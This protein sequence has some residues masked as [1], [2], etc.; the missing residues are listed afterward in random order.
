M[1]AAGPAF[2]LQGV[3]EPRGARALRRLGQALGGMAAL[4]AV[5]AAG[6]TQYVAWR[7][8]W[9]PALGDPLAGGVYAPWAV[10]DWAKRDWPAAAPAF[11]EARSGAVLAFTLAGALVLLA[12]QRGKRRPKPHEGVHGTARWASEQECRDAGLLAP[13][14][15]APHEGLFVGAFET[16]PGRTEYLRATGPVNVLGVGPLRSGKTQGI[17][18]PNLLSWMGSVIVNDP[19]GELWTAT[20]GWRKKHAGTA[21]LRWAPGDTENTARYNFLDE[22]R[23]GQAQEFGDVS[24]IIESVADP[25]GAGFDGKDHWLPTAAELLIGVTLYNLHRHR[26][27]AKRPA[28]LADTRR[29]L[30]DPDVPA[31]KLFEAML[32]NRLA[33]GGK[34]HEGIAEIGRAQLNR[35]EKERGSVTSTA[36]RMMRL[37]ADPVVARNTSRS[38]FRINDLMDARTP[39][40]LYKV[41]PEDRRL[42]LLPLARLL[43]TLAMNK[44][45]SAPMPPG[46]GRPHRHPL[47]FVGEEF[48]FYGRMDDLVDRLARCGQAGIQALLLVQEYPQLLST[49][50]Q[51][52]AVTG[53]CHV[54]VFHTPNDTRT[55]ELMSALADRA[56]V[57][58]EQIGESGDRYGTDRG[59]NRSFQTVSRSLLTPGEAARLKVPERDA[60]GRVTAP[61]QVMVSYAGHFPVL[62]VQ[63]LY[64][65]D[66]TFR[67]RAAVPPPTTDRLLP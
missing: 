48:L 7:L 63:S 43:L 12:S 33:P 13:R 21:V 19:K 25:S 58:T 50:G 18:V 3:P 42:Q 11:V 44:L 35:P 34:R 14:R 56:T 23:L 52:E 16:K 31:D 47:L 65:L 28:C 6:A 24:T 15:G 5:A 57:I 39:V 49:Y 51:N 54:K 1:T 22:V 55:A 4:G 40:S 66:E 29:A 41:I 64:F 45:M 61:G 62:G 30:Q 20:A 60:G 10:F 53:K 17:A 38:D 27:E 26:A 37:F 67:A 46:G 59:Y 9:H 2:G 8:D 36:V 32:N